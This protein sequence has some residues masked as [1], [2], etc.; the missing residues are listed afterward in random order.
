VLDGSAAFDKV[1]PYDVADEWKD[2]HGAPRRC[3]VWDGEDP[4][5]GMR[6]V[7]TIDTDPDC[8]EWPEEGENE[9]AHRFWRWYERPAG[10]DG[11]GS[12]FAVKTV[13]LEHHRHDVAQQAE[14]MVKALGLPADI[15]T[16][17]TLAARFH[18]LGKRRRLWQR[19][20][21]NLDPAN[22]L[23]KSGHKTKA[24]YTTD[25]RHELGSLLDLEREEAFRALHDQPELQDLVRHLVAAHHG[26]ARPHFPEDEVC[27]PERPEVDVAATAR[28]VP[29]RFARLQ[30]KYGRWG[31]AYLESLVRAADALASQFSDP[32]GP[33]PP[34][35]SH[36]PTRGVTR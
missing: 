26:R 13:L 11:D 3:R 33:K 19:N 27:D 28:E 15:Q 16:A 36:T 14:R 6:L 12:R 30:R 5:S 21:G 8:D 29:R 10:G 9:P 2:A 7:R 1:Q 18:D 32:G 25:Y 23:A 35:P 31:L 34:P 17:V 24:L 20:I 22:P 4:P